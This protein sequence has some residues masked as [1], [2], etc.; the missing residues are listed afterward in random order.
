MNLGKAS[1]TKPLISSIFHRKSPSLW[2]NHILSQLHTNHIFTQLLTNHILTQLH[3][4]HI[5][6]QLLTNHDCFHSYL[7]KMKKAP[8]PLCSCPEKVEQK[9]HLMMTDQRYFKTSP[10]L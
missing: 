6:T 4:N 5:L 9:A 8:T 10:L 7:H 3:T 2:P 1:H